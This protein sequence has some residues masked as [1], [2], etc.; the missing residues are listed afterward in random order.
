[1]EALVLSEY[2]E[3]MRWILKSSASGLSL[4]KE[5]SE[6]Y[7][8]KESDELTGSEESTKSSLVDIYM[9]VGTDVEI[10]YGIWFIALM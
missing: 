2:F 4:L 9:A 3:V 7:V 10:P 8:T 1:M 5:I 6:F